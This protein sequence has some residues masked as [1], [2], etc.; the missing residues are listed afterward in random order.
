LLTS[1]TNVAGPL[2]RDYDD[3][4]VRTAVD[5]SV[6]AKGATIAMTGS[7]TYRIPVVVSDAAAA[8]VAEGAEI[9]PTDP[10]PTEVAV[11][12]AK[13][14]ALTVISSELAEDSTPAAAEIVGAG[15]AR[16]IARKI[17]AAVASSLASPTPDGL[18][19]LVGFSPYVDADAWSNLDW[20]AHALS[21]AGSVG[22]SLTASVASP[23]TASELATVRVATGSNAAILGADPTSPTSR[24]VAGVPL[25]VSQYVEDDVIWGLDR[26]T[27]S[28]WSGT[29]PRSQPIG[30]FSSQVT[31]SRSAA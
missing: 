11:T 6:F 1:T 3:L 9:T 20:S 27:G 18:T 17:D 28:W 29:T 10:T 19:D 5:E 31:G 22:A 25:N 4:V 12:P 23:A 30:P 21:L 14:A 24:Q 13:I 26:S 7:H 15:L 2:P 16:A 8:G